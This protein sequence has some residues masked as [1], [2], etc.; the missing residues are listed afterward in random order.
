MAHN[1][2]IMNGKE[3]ER[4]FK[5][6][7]NRRRIAII[8]YLKNEK[9]ASVG[10]IAETIRLSLKAT[11]KHLGILSA[12]DIVEKEQKSLMMFYRLSTE[13]KTIIKHL[14]SFL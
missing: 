8:R 4:I 14:I 2:S 3:L 13:Q 10:D 1:T 9:E 7:A 11:S 5:A 12:V 6:F